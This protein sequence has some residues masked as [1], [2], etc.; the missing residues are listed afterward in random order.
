MTEQALD[1]LIHGVILDTARLE[2]GVLL[3]ETPEPYLFPPA[4]SEG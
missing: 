1:R 3:K 4:S 2:Y